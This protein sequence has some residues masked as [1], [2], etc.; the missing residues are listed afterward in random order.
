MNAPFRT[1]FALLVTLALPLAACGGG[2]DAAETDTA[3]TETPEPAPAQEENRVEVGLTEFEITM[4][5]SVPAGPTT[6]SIT[7][8]GTMEHSFEIEGPGMEQ[9]LAAPLVAGGSATLD[10]TLEPGTYRVYCPVA[11]HAEARGMETELQVVPAGA[12]TAG[13]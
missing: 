11:D 4:P 5:S 2:E 6:F 13:M 7:N 10:L 12:S 3:T 9:A 1:L 8:N